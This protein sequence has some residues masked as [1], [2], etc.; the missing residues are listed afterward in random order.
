MAVCFSR[1]GRTYHR[2]HHHGNATASEKVAGTG[3]PD[4]HLPNDAS[5][6]RA[7]IARAINSR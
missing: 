1:R 3:G 6:N 2:N 4:N 7:I 5:F